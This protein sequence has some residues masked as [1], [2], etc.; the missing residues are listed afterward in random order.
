MGA[1]RPSASVP[2]NILEVVFLAIF[3]AWVFAAALFIRNTFL[4]RLPVAVTLQQLGLPGQTVNFLAT[5]GLRLEAWK[6]PGDPHRPWIIAC[7]GLG[8]N[9]MDLLEVTAGLQQAGFNLLLIDFRAHGGSEGRVSSFG[10][11]EQRDLEGALAWLGSQPDVPPKPYGVFGVSMGGAVAL[12]VGARDER[13]GAVAVDSP[14]TSL[15][16][17]LAQHQKL[18]YP[19]LPTQPFL[20]F[21][22]STYRLQFGVWPDQVSPLQSVERLGPRPLLVIQGG[23]DARM[24]ADGA[25]RIY[26]AAAGPKQIW[27]VEG[28]GHMEAFSQDSDAY[29]GSLVSFFESSLQ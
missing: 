24:S 3:W 8:A 17:S 22:L 29:R 28:A 25:K 21:V 12:M 2:L 1:L 23:A 6:I 16:E 20:A 7:H 14:Y 10:W 4:P 15:A 11:R 19:W 13:V 5:D 26:A 9:R 27:L 18:L